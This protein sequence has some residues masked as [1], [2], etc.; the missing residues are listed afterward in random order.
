MTRFQSLRWRIIVGATLWTIGL[1]PMGHI[2]FLVVTGRSHERFIGVA[3]LGLSS[4][5]LLLAT[6]FLGAGIAQVR[7]GLM[8]FD[9]L[10]AHLSAVR[11]GVE[12][13]IEGTY[14]AE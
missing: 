11:K 2:F 10:K 13:R 9:Q 6:V 7:R 12:Q 4:A 8:P 5:F 1:L 3:H 14:P